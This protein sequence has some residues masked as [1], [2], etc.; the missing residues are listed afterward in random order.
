MSK[1]KS[2]GQRGEECSCVVGCEELTGP[3]SQRARHQ[4]YVRTVE[5]R[6]IGSG[7]GTEGRYE[8]DREGDRVTQLLFLCDNW[9]SL[10]CILQLIQ[11]YRDYH[12]AS[13]GVA[14]S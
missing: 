14:N 1:S 5:V 10:R 8:L 7:A 3:R 13:L 6:E 11:S 12:R 2:T 4:L 9:M